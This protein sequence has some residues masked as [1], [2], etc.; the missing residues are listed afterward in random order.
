MADAQYTIIGAGVVGLAIAARLSES[1][2]D[3]F[4]IEKHLQYGQEV[5]SRNS[6]VIHS[7]IYYPRGSLKA[8]MCVRGRELLY[9]LCESESIDYRKCGKLIVANTPEEEK[10]LEA[11]RAKGNENGVDDLVLLDREEVEAIEPNVR[12]TRALFSPSTGIVDSHGLMKWLYNR[13]ISNGTEIVFGTKV[14]QIEPIRIGYRLELA[15]TTG[16]RFSFTTKNLINCAGLESDLI[17]HMAGIRDSLYQIHFCKGEYFRVNP[18]KDKLVSRLIYPVPGRKLVGLGIHATIDLG[19]SLKLGPSAFYLPE[20]KYDYAV[21]AANAL[22]FYHSA[23]AFLPFL[24]PDD[25]TPDIAGIRPKVQ[26]P[27]E[28]VRDFIIVHEKDRG[29]PGLVNCIGIESPGLTSALAIAEYV[30]QLLPSQV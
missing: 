1:N 18:P 2:Q 6:E 29:F 11:L 19:G 5:S 28:P 30:E 24:E 13:A 9:R 14:I 26:G 23:M 22:Q 4:I 17:A 21:D 8:R 20:R 12:T 25:L 16:D 7:G 3:V 15:D 10:E 27:G